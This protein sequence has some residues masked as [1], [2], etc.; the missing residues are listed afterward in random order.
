MLYLQH[1]ST[2]LEYGARC[3]I[4]QIYQTWRDDALGS[5]RKPPRPEGAIVRTEYHLNRYD[6]NGSIC[7][8]KAVND[9]R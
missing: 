6:G 5:L 3:I 4:K 2:D 8:K 9:I 7:E 1:H